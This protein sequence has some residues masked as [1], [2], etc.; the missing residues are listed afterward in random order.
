MHSSWHKKFFKKGDP[1]R[2]INSTPVVLLTLFLSASLAS[3]SVDD[4]PRPVLLGHDDC[5][6]CQMTLT[7]GQFACE[8]ITDK[9]KCCKFDVV[10]CLF[11]YLAMNVISDE[12][13]LKIYVGDFLH[14]EE[15]ID[16]K[17]ATLVL[18]MDIHSPM[19]GGVAAF[20]D[21][22]AA[23]KFAEH[24]NSIVL[25]SWARLKKVQQLDDEVP[26]ATDGEMTAR[27]D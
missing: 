4:K 23:F 17:S 3:C 19:G 26:M 7:D 20:S 15:L 16:L 27:G 5:A 13:V 6:A 2:A 21:K 14:P 18:G 10:S 1:L 11:N 12:S 24:T 8:V 9:G 22:D 25:D